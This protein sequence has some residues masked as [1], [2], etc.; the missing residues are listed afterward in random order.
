[1]SVQNTRVNK[2]FRRRADFFIFS[3]DH[4]VP[5]A[6]SIIFGVLVVGVW[7]QMNFIWM[8]LGCSAPFLTWL[9]VVGKSPAR[10]MAKYIQP[11]R[12]RRGR[13]RRTRGLAKPWTPAVLYQRS[14]RRGDQ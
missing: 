3:P 5:F 6:L 8:M 7:L 12:W 2:S 10:T 14:I 1:M 13:G 4:M 9:I 11:P